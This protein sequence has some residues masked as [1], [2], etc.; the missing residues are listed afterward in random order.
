MAL[1]VTADEV[2]ITYILDKQAP[3][4][5]HVIR[6]KQRCATSEP[7]LAVPGLTYGRHRLRQLV[8]AY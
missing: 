7:G 6:M 2:T 4:V 8:L 5:N 1:S 3:K